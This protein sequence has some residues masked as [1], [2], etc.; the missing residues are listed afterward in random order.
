A[1]LFHA[2]GAAAWGRPPVC[3]CAGPPARRFRA[4]RPT[5]PEP[6]CTAQ[7]GLHPTTES[8]RMDR[9]PKA[10]ERRRAILLVALAG[11]VGA[12]QGAAS[13]QPPASGLVSVRSYSGQFVAYAARS[14]TLPAA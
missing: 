14:V 3:R 6:P 13:A 7:P 5:E 9:N 4:P 12:L 2:S 8:L 10:S 11:L 1:M